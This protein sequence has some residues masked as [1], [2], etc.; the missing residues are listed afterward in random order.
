[1]ARRAREL[2]NARGLGEI[3]TAVRPARPPRPTPRQPTQTGRPAIGI[4]FG[5]TNSAIGLIEGGDVRLIPNAEGHLTTPS[6]VAIAA[7]GTTLV[8]TAAKRQAL[9]NPEYTVRSVKLKLGTG[10]SIARG[11]VRLTA[12]DAAALILARLRTDAE[13]YLGGPMNGA[14]LTVPANFGQAQRFAL[15]RAA[16]NAGITAWRMVN[17]PTA[18]AV[19]FGLNRQDDLTVLIFDLGGGT[20]DVSILEVS[21]GVVEVKSTAGEN[22]L[23][24]DD[25]DRRI[26]QHLAGLAQQR[27]GVDLADDTAAMRRLQ[28]A[29]EA[30]KV[31]LSS[32]RTAEVQLPY[33]ATTLDSPFHLHETMDRDAFEAITRDILERC[34]RPVEQALR[35]AGIGPSGID[36]VILTG[37]A[38]RM[39]AIGR[40]VGEITGGKHVY[41]GLIP[42]GVVTGATLQA[43]ILTGYVKDVLL[44]DVTSA[45][46]GVETDGG[47]LAQVAERNTTIPTLATEIFATSRDGQTA[48]VLHFAEGGEP[49]IHN[50]KSLAVLELSGLSPAPRGTPVIEV[51]IDIDANGILTFSAKELRGAAKMLPAKAA[52]LRRL[53]AE[54]RAAWPRIEIPAEFYTGREVTVTVDESSTRQARQLLESD[55][56]PALRQNI[57]SRW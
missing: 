25:W 41:R 24:G 53:R 36:H 44:L 13:A 21:D 43:G 17:E 37:G 38:T 48:T 52:E 34:R 42:E 15:A 10:W 6:L 32:A 46:I 39:P 16:E 51:I 27:Y 7:D 35:D 26:V 11:D 5:T 54:Q 23:G 3:P 50:N 45:P 56:W 47:L 29:A 9:T 40:L 55:G 33:L 49:T 18:A 2:W 28:E 19:T 14:V 57:P 22:C 1:V 8:G 4:D 31:A 12:E 20:L 30:A